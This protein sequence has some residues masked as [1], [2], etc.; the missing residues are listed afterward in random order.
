MTDPSTTLGL[1]LL[2][3]LELVAPLLLQAGQ[4]AVGIVLM[5]IAVER[6]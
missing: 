4:L 3:L 1:V 6:S 5:V 2:L